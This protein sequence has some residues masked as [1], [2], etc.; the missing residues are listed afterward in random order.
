MTAVARLPTPRALLAPALRR[1]ASAATRAPGGVVLADPLQAP[2]FS[3]RG[4]TSGT[5]TTTTR[6][7]AAGRTGSDAV[8]VPAATFAAVTSAESLRADAEHIGDA[9]AQWLDEEW[10]PLPEHRALG[11][12]V[13]DI[14]VRLRSAGGGGGDAD[15]VR[16][17]GGGGGDADD[18]ASVLLGLAGELTASFDF[19]PTFT[20]AFDVANKVIE[21]AMQ[22]DG[23]EVCDCGGGGGREGGGV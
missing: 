2:I 16:S 22:R 20:S 14:Y 12:A 13:S 8:P 23:M 21:V 15:D 6:R 9:V 10:A 5:R 17:A 18:V 1:L 4:S 11:R 19:G 3:R 7:R